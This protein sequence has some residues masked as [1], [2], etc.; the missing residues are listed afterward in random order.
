M[1]CFCSYVLIKSLNLDWCYVL[2]GSIAKMRYDIIIERSTYIGM[3]QSTAKQHNFLWR[4][5]E[6]RLSAVSK[7]FKLDF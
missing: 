5:A 3:L 7:K 2:H 6:L 1:I 4:Y